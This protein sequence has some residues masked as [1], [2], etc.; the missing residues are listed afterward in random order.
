MLNFCV[1]LFSDFLMDLILFLWFVGSVYVIGGIDVM[2]LL[3]D[4]D[5]VVGCFLL[6]GLGFVIGC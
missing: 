4:V 6:D 5:D 1:S 3:L 2:V